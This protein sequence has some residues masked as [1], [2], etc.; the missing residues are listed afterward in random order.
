MDQTLPLDQRLR[1][2]P[3]AATGVVAPG[4]DAPAAD[5]QYRAKAKEAAEKFEGF[6]ISQMLRQMRQGNAG[7][8]G[9]DGVY[10]KQEN[11][12]MLDIADVQLAESLS[13]LHAFGIADAILRQI[14]PPEAA[15]AASAAPA[16]KNPATVVASKD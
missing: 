12:D 1:T 11:R 16:F 4:S 2:A 10:G 5:A 14:L 13:G 8:A 7:I 6:F 9:E 15:P 3:A